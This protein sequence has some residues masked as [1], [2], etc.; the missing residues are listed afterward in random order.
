[1]R[2]AQVSLRFQE[3]TLVEKFCVEKICPLLVHFEI[4][5]VVTLS[6]SPISSDKNLIL[7]WKL[8]KN[9][10]CLIQWLNSG[11][12]QYLMIDKRSIWYS[13]IE[14][15]R[16]KF[17]FP[18][19]RSRDNW[20][21]LPSD[22]KLLLFFVPQALHKFRKYQHI[23]SGIW[24]ATTFFCNTLLLLTIHSS[25]YLQYISDICCYESMQL[26]ASDP[27]LRISVIIIP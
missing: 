11:N 17:K 1:M 13:D 14:I 12:F 2:L 18:F 10:V 21:L 22:E 8:K 26:R 27:I 25:F 19:S 5:D 6:A 15:L 23:S 24:R 20:N 16:V 7:Y 9:L 4:I 3:F